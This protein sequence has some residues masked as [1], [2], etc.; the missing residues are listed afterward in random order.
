DALLGTVTTG[1]IWDTSALVRVEPD[2]RVVSYPEVFPERF[3]A[4]APQGFDWIVGNPPWV[5]FQG[6]ATQRISPE[7]RAFC[8][9]HYRAFSGYPTLHGMFIGRAAE[10]APHGRVTLLV[11]SSVS[12]LEGYRGARAALR[13]THDLDEPMPEFGQDAFEGVVQPCFGLIARGRARPSVPDENE[14]ARPWILTER[15]HASSAIADFP[16]PE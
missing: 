14:L 7:R 12:D 13:K 4:S 2:V 3:G 5:A 15:T 9:Q 10:L 8:R 11:P 1:Q 6:R 16:P